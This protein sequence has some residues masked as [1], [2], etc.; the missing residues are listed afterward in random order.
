MKK[1]LLF[2]ISIKITCVHCQA[3]KCA[4]MFLQMNE[5][6][7]LTFAELRKVKQK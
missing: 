4:K 1:I 7:H 6:E 5:E 3:I 2:I